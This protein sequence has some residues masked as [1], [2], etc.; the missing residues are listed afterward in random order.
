MTVR[1]TL[2][3]LDHIAGIAFYLETRSPLAAARIVARI[4]R[5]AE[6]LGEFPHLG[7]AGTVP[8]TREWIVSGLPYI[9][10]HEIGVTGEV[11]VL[12]VFHGAQERRDTNNHNLG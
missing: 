2:E 7:H 12:A 4:F 1:F 5:E 11:T 10:V 9:I 6:R 3:A 8:G